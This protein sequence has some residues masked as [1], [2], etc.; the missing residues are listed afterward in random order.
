MP[1]S[2]QLTFTLEQDAEGYWRAVVRAPGVNP[3]PLT[4]A[5][6]TKKQALRALVVRLSERP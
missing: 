3:H 1:E 2:V 5:Y 6:V 4:A